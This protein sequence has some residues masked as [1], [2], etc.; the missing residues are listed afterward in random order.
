M[1]IEKTLKADDICV[2]KLASGE[3]LIAK[4]HEE[5]DAG[6][7]ISKPLILNLGMDQKTNQVGI[8][9]IPAFMLAASNDMRLTIRKH[10]VI[11]LAKAA[12]DAKNGYIRNTTGIVMA[13]PNLTNI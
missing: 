10:A 4:F 3:E 2:I 8:Q 13:G 9:M 1:L 6:V 12:D 7:S 11:C 5:T